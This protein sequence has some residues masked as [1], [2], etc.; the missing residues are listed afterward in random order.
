MR[1]TDLLGRVI[2]LHPTSKLLVAGS[3]PAGRHSSRVHSGNIGDGLFRRGEVT[4]L[5]PKGFDRLEPA[6]LV[7][8]VAEIV[9]QLSWRA[10][11][12]RRPA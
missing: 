1:C 11:D 5:E 8:E 6:S 12:G 2:P 7:V 4:L 3:N 10:R 9:L